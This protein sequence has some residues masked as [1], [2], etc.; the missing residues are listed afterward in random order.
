[1]ACISARWFQM[2]LRILS[3]IFAGAVSSSSSSSSSILS[4]CVARPASSSGMEL[5]GMRSRQATR[6]K[7]RKESARRFLD[8]REV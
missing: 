8:T 4:L 2:N 6:E 5:A 3:S 7:E 1:M